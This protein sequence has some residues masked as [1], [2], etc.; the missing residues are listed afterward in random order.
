MTA[1][2][3]AELDEENVPQAVPVQLVPLAVQVTLELSLVVAFTDVACVTVRPAFRGVTV[4]VTGVP[5]EIVKLAD[6]VALCV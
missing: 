3:L 4:T 6:A 2:P 1:V 5:D